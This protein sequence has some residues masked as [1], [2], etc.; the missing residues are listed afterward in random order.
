M[1]AVT[2]A[3]LIIA[4]GI[5]WMTL[6][7]VWVVI[8]VIGGFT[9]WRFGQEWFAAGATWAQVGKSW[10]NTYELVEIKFSVDGLNRVLRL[11]DSSGRQIYSFRLRDFQANARMWDLAYNGILHSVASGNCQ[12]TPSARKALMLPA[13]LGM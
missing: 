13:G 4:N 11:K 3:F 10:V 12:V 6:W 5:Q 7:Q 2:A 8:A 9:Y 1:T